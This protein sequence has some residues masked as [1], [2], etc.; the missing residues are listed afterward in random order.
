VLP[1]RE[2][3]MAEETIFEYVKKH[4][5]KVIAGTG[6]SDEHSVGMREVLDIK[7]G[8]IEKYG[9]SYIYL[10]TSVPIEKFVDAAIETNADVIMI[11]LIIS[12]D[13]VHYK[14]MEKLHHYAI[15]KGVRDKLILLA[16]GTQVTPEL[17]RSHGMDQGFSRGT[18]GRHVASFI[19]KRHQEMYED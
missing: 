8:G 2:E 9:I 7:H 10:G 14:N 16:G 17:A 18:K 11:S 13:D 3:L 1:E 12:H 6:G 19:V 5:I 4:P 15:E